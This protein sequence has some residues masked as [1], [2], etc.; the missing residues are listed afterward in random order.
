VSAFLSMPID[1]PLSHHILTPPLARSLEA[2]GIGA[3]GASALAAILKETKIT[4]LGCASTRECSLSCTVSALPNT[5]FLCPF[6]NTF[7]RWSLSEHIPSFVPFRTHSFLGPQ[8]FL[9]SLAN[10]HAPSPFPSTRCRPPSCA[11]W[12]ATT[13]S[14]RTGGS[15]VLPRPSHQPATSLPQLGVQQPRRRD[16]TGRQRRRGQRRPH[17]FLASG[18]GAPRHRLASH[19]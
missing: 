12:T 10:A 13:C 14:Y 6:Q 7:L 9:H 17:H 2:N 3:E 8:N 11:A 1:T 15:R 16:P 19:T 4:H 18:R 5:S